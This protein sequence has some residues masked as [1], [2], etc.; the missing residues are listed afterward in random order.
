MPF[1]AAADAP[2][3]SLHGATFTGLAAPG[4][5]A[6]ETAAWI[7][8]LGAHTPG[9]PHRLSREEIFIGLEGRALARVGEV[10]HEIGV[11]CA[12]IVPADTEFQIANPDAAPFR[13]VAV[14]PV[15]GRATLAGGEP[16]TPPWAV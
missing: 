6:R 7:V 3:F 8:T 14:L 16:F 4:R 11:G 9:A 1:I 2:T 12:L 13:A 5:G 10:T 15:G